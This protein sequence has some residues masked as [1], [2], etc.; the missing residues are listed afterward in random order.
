LPKGIE[1]KILDEMEREAQR[2][3]RW[4]PN[5]GSGYLAQNGGGSA[6]LRLRREESEE[7]QVFSGL[8]SAV[9]RS[10]IIAS[11]EQMLTQV[12]TRLSFI[13]EA[14]CVGFAVVDDWRL[15]Q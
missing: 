9:E 10:V 7:M 12:N 3:M 13:Q 6:D 4:G 11:R 14:H 8:Q 5:Q 2:G 15:P 1:G